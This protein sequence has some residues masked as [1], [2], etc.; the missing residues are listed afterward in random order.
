MEL[1][2][3]RLVS[4]ALDN[5]IGCY[6]AAE[7]ARLVAE[8]GGAPGDVL[9]LAVVQEETTLRR[10][11]DQRLRASSPTWRSSST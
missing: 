1:P 2:N 3:D 8:D 10:R 6:V 9:A 4:R 5:R 7:A 11:A